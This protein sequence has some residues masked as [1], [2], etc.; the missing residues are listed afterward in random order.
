MNTAVSE[1]E[2]ADIEFELGYVAEIS[3]K[4]NARK[5]S[6]NEEAPGKCLVENAP[7]CWSESTSPHR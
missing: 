7:Q 6:D 3:S 5:F 1:A 4:P 2:A